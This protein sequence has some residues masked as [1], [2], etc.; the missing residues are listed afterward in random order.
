MA[1]S[2]VQNSQQIT[3]LDRSYELKCAWCHRQRWTGMLLSTSFNLT[4]DIRWWKHIHAQWER[5]ENGWPRN[6]STTTW[7]EKKLPKVNERC[8]VTLEPHKITETREQ[9]SLYPLSLSLSL[10]LALAHS[11]S[12][13]IIITI[14]L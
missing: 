13:P 12:S 9:K 5:V 3:Q 14:T 4:H 1:Q 10:P 8:H 2:Q 11:L 6:T 7:V